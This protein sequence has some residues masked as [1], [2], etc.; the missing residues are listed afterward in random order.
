MRNSVYD[1]MLLL[2]VCTL[3]TV[4]TALI[5]LVIWAGC[6]RFVWLPVAAQVLPIDFE[7]E[8]EQ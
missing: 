1:W 2:F 8:P 3:F 7:E 6:L 4:G 5:L